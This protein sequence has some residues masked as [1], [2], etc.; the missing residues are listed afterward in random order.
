MKTK[1]LLIA[2]VMFFALS[3]VAFS[4]AAVYSVSSTPITTVIAT[5]NAEPAGD[6]TFTQTGGTSVL[7]TISL[8]YGGNN[9]NI[10]NPFANITITCTGGYAASC[11]TVNNTPISQYSPGLLVISIPAG[12]APSIPGPPS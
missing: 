10:T 6:I 2:A 7:G 8:Q 11:P 4:Q 3:A 9:V 12:V 1:T 5:G